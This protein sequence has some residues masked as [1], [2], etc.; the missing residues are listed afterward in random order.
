MKAETVKINSLISQQVCYTL[1]LF[2][3]KYVWDKPQWE[4]L[5]ED[6]EFLQENP[7]AADHFLGSMVEMPILPP[8]RGLSLYTLI[9]G[10]QRLTTIFIMLIAL[11]N[12]MEA[13]NNPTAKEVHS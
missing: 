4:K 5:W 3:R 7:D 8:V 6:M 2:Q 10:Q 1:P 9:D 12:Q 11:R 13:N